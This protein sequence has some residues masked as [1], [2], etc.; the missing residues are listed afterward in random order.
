[1]QLDNKR[2]IAGVLLLVVLA[3]GLALLP[4]EEWVTALRAWIQAYPVAG[5]MLFAVL[6]VLGMLLLVPVSLQAMTC[7]FLFG[8]GAGFALMCIGGLAGFAAA[9]LAGRG[10]AR[11]WVERVVSERPGFASIDAAVRNRGFT[12][13]LLTRLSLVVPYNLLNYALG[14]TAVSMRDYLLA[15]AVGML[16]GL[17]LFVFIGSTATEFGE[18][19]TGEAVPSDQNLLFTLGGLV[20]LALLM[21]VLTGAA[22]RILRQELENES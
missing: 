10:L 17:F 6:I 2:R 9:F 12:V 22:R 21:I 15:S 18:I 13:V 19:L 3:S 16:P 8:A 20:L 14:L 5:A 11:P 4:L 7:G 1:M